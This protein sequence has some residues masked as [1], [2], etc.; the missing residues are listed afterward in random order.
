M[1]EISPKT[2][3]A[4][5]KQLWELDQFLFECMKAGAMPLL[6]GYD[7]DDLANRFDDAA[8]VM[9]EKAKNNA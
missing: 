3:R 9:F 7:L 2:L 5:A 8:R 6:I 4:A 1:P